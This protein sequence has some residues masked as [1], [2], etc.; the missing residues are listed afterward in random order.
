[1]NERSFHF[2]Y[3]PNVIFESIEKIFFSYKLIYPILFI[4]G[5][6]SGL[7]LSI[8]VIFCLIT[9]LFS[10][11]STF[12]NRNSDAISL[13]IISL[14]LIVNYE[15]LN[16]PSFIRYLIYFSAIWI[17]LINN[18]P[19]FLKKNLFLF[20]ALFFT[21]LVASFASSFQSYIEFKTQPLIRDLFV[22]F[23]LLI[24]CL[25]PKINKINL[26]FL[27]VLLTGVLFGEILY[28]LTN[29]YSTYFNYSSVKTLILFI[30]YFLLLKER[31]FL[32]IF[33]LFLC[34]I[35]ISNY[36]TRMI[37]L[38]LIFFSILGLVIFLL[39]KGTTRSIIA[40]IASIILSIFAIQFLLSYEYLQGLKAIAFLTE[41]YDPQNTSIYEVFKILDPVRYAEHQIFFSRSLLEILFGNGLGAGIVDT[42]GYLG[43]VNYFQSAFSQE[44]INSNT[45]FN[46]HDYWIDYGLRFGLIPVL[47][48]LFYTAISPMLLGN[49]FTGIF[50]GVMLVC[51]TYSGS[52]MLIFALL[53]KYSGNKKIIAN[54]V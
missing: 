37:L 6:I 38:S 26:S 8:S 22:L 45:Y 7:K 42:D 23:L 10:L 48:I 14:Y 12:I 40:G 20:L 17:L 11:F 21:I 29:E 32:A 16:T 49:T 43:F 28:V 19:L 3:L 1:M 41:F 51:I 34:F 24:F 36:G 2:D 44:E 18:R 52:G 39:R 31:K 47:L 13:I 53:V 50:N 25:L 30:P 54:Q 46:L 35:A 9:L 15:I 5:F 4:I 33:S 27:F